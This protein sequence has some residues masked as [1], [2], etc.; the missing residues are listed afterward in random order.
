MSLGTPSIT[1]FGEILWDLLPSGPRIGGAPANL[2][3]HAADAG[4]D[5]ALVSAVGDDPLGRRIRDALDARGFPHGLIQT[6]PARPTGTVDIT[7]DAKGA[8]TYRIN[9]D[10]AWDHIRL[11][12][13]N[14]AAAARADAFCFGTL[15]QRSPVSRATLRALLD[16]L[17]PAAVR[18]LDVN[19]RKPPPADEVLRSSLAAATHLKLNDEELP[20]LA[21]LLGAAPGD[22]RAAL[23]ALLDGNPGLSVILLTRGPDGADILTRSEC[24]HLPAADV[25]GLVDTV[26]AGD[27]FTAGFVIATLRG[28]AP[29]Q[30]ATA[31]NALAAKV[32]AT[33]GAWLPAPHKT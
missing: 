26:G 5:T 12:P 28:A 8:A 2:A 30:A 17:P 6:E 13:E 16:N 25:P 24:F 10:V 29:R 33:A 3:V 19:L 1:V 21:A 11:T 15:A 27:A 4:L 22:E 14:T 18:L 7:L 9:G 31:G 23:D 20:R 32:C